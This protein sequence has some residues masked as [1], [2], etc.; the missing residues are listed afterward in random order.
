MMEL[1]RVDYASKTNGAYHIVG[2]YI[3]YRI[4]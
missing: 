1:F 4:V 2:S 3:V